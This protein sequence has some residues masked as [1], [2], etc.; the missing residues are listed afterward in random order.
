MNSKALSEAFKRGGAEAL[1]AS[2]KEARGYDWIGIYVKKGD[3]L[4]LALELGGTA[5]HRKI[6]VGEGICGMAAKKRQT[7][8]VQDVEQEPNY[9]ACFPDTRSELVIPILGPGQEVLGE[10]DVDDDQMGRFGL[11]E[12]E[13]LEEA[14]RLLSQGWEKIKPNLFSKG[15][16]AA[17]PAE[18]PK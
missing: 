3:Y 16:G 9:L 11:E 12:R 18:G 17:S 10:I 15:Y 2:L 8:V 5:S 7:V 13:E 1:L 4:E 14:A 6:R